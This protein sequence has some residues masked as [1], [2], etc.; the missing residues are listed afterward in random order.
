[1]AEKIY[2]PDYDEREALL[3]YVDQP[4]Q[5]IDVTP[6]EI[7]AQHEAAWKELD[8]MFTPEQRKQFGIDTP[9]T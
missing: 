6:P 3:R 4:G 1:M 2:N 7:K 5:W 9:S 8:A